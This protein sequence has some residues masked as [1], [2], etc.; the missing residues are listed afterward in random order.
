[1]KSPDIS[2]HLGLN[3]T[4]KKKEKEFVNQSERKRVD[5]F[6][7]HQCIIRRFKLNYR[8]DYDVLLGIRHDIESI[9]G[10]ANIWPVPRLRF[11]LSSTKITLASMNFLALPDFVG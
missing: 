11:E 6:F 1:M 8:D 3:I 9:L 5:S 7:I 10:K 4:L 2:N